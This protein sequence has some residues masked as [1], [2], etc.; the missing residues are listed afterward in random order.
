MVLNYDGDRYVLTIEFEEDKN[1]LS[2][3]DLLREIKEEYYD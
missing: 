2:Y 1:N 3:L